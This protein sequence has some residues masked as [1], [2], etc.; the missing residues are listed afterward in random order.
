M[1]PDP[2]EYGWWLASRS[3]GIVAMVLLS[4]SVILGLLMANGLPARPGV[5]RTQLNI[6][7]TTALAG[8]IAIAVHGLTLLGDSYLHPSVVDIAVPFTIS[9]RPGFTG[10]GII[11]G[12]LA[13]F[14]G[15]TFY[16]RKLIGNK[17]WRA[18]HRA[19]II[20]WVLGVIHTLGG[21]TDAGTVWL[22]VILLV[23]GIPIVFLFIRRLIPEAANPSIPDRRPRRERNA[24]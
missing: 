18:I 22:Q 5:K 4:V 21:G 23:T 15:L 3:A 12:W 8:L 13:A 17:R 20:V 16:T 2:F 19:T 6:H 7:E 14:L 10:V 9:Y 1:N 11:A 24:A